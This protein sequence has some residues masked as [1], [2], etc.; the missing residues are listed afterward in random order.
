MHKDNDP[1]CRRR[2]RRAVEIIKSTTDGMRLARK[3]MEL[4]GGKVE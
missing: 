1:F 3:A 4:I 2:R